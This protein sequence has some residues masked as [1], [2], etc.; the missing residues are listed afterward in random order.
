MLHDGKKQNRA[1]TVWLAYASRSNVADPEVA[2][3]LNRRIDL[4]RSLPF[5]F[6][7][8]VC[9]VIHVAYR[10][11]ESRG[12]MDSPSPHDMPLIIFELTSSQIPKG[13]VPNVVELYPRTHSDDIHPE[14]LLFKPTQSLF[15]IRLDVPIKIIRIIDGQE[16]K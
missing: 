12:I 13:H 9:P 6:L 2:T 3:I 15:Q 14:T 10:H 5:L 11:T 1:T 16:T 4:I 7:S 8:I